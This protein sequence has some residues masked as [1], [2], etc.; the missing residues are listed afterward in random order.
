MKTIIYIISTALVFTSCITSNPIVKLTPNIAP[1]QEYWKLGQQFVYAKTDNVWFDCAFNRKEGDKI[2]FDVKIDNQS[3]SAVLADPARCYQSVYGND[4]L[5]ITRNRAF[6]PEQVLLFLDMQER[7]A[8]QQASNAA[9]L[10]V[11]TNLL[12]VGAN[13]AVETSNKSERE[14][15]RTIN[16]INAS[17]AAVQVTTGAI[18]QS[19]DIRAERNWVTRRNLAMQFLRK[20]TLMPNQYIDGEVHFPYNKDAKWYE[21][22]LV[23]GGSKV[24]FWFNQK[25][26]YPSYN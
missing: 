9:A 21:I 4:S 2:V 13:I 17:N 11:F 7:M 24:V 1:N 20:T 14:K 22:T 5:R 16:A 8:A 18:A 6:D 12:T 23:A 15:A 25:L 3:D 19:S 10:G 26:I